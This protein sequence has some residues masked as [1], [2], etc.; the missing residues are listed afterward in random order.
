MG[1]RRMGGVKT[2]FLMITDLILGLVSFVLKILNGILS[3]IPLNVPPQ[4]GTAFGYFAGYLSYAGGLIDL[5]GVF[6][7]FSFLL[8]FIIAWFTFKAVMWIVH[9]V[10]KGAHENQALPTQNKK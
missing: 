9:L 6:G 4:V 2:Y 5:P 10:R 8:N 7:A 3:A 1:Q